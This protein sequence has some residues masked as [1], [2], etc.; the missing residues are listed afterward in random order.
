VKADGHI[1]IWPYIEQTLSTVPVNSYSHLRPMKAVLGDFDLVGIPVSSAL[2]ALLPA[3]EELA[4]DLGAT[5]GIEPLP[6]QAMSER[7]LRKLERLVNQLL[8][9]VRRKPT[10]T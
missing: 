9:Q 3:M 6:L 1:T 7:E 2:K 5:E 4:S 10:P 8:E